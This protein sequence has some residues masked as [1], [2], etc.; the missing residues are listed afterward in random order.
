[1][2]KSILLVGL[3][4]AAGVNTH[5]AMNFYRVKEAEQGAKKKFTLDERAREL[6][7]KSTKEELKRLV[8]KYIVK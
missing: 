8:R 3:L 6:I 5:A 4:L 1:M 2:K 7:A